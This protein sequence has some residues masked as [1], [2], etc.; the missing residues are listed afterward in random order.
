MKKL[1]AITVAL[2]LMASFAYAQEGA[3][4]ITPLGTYATGLFDEGGAEIVTYDSENQRAIVVNSGEGSSL[5]FID[6]SDPT[7]PTLAFSVDLT[8][9][10]DGANSV[11]YSNGTVAVAVQA[12]AVDANGVVVF[13][14]TEGNELAVVTAGALPDMVTFSPDGN[15]VLVANEGEPNDAYDID[16]EGTVSIIDVSGG[17]DGLTDDA[18][19][20]VQFTDVPENIRTFGPNATPAQDLEPEYIAVSP[21][22]TTAYV[23][24]QENN[25][26]AVID[27]A[28]ASVAAIVDL[29][30]KDYSL[31]ENA[32][33]ASNEDGAINIQTWPVLSMYQPD[34][35]ATYEVEGEVYIVTA[36][37][38]DAR[39]YDGF[40]EEA[41]VADITL[42]E[43]AF[44]NAAELQAEDQLGRL[45]ITTTLGDTD[46]DG[47]FDALY[48][49]GAR[50]FSIWNSAGELVFDSTNDFERITA[51]LI[52]DAFNSQG[53]NESFDNRSDDKGPEPEA[54]AIGEVD[55]AI[56]AFIAMERVGGIFVYDVSDP[57]APVY[58]TYANNNIPEGASEELT[59]G[60]VAPESVEFVPADASPTGTPLL[61]V[62][63]EVSG[64][65]TVWEISSG[66]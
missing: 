23:V 32:I 27:I 38:G 29:G 55:G 2:L 30:F 24:M 62:G 64:T 45:L 21:D 51:E 11:D 66:M 31:E 5:D 9:Y 7:T 49:Y 20:S 41:R 57:V 54:V 33:D 42:D 4:S 65:T 18:V 25:A 36:N 48:G 43:E 40:S 16:P 52:P 15:T 34:T 44:P 46:G 3:I 12:E 39:D 19:T 53:A 28:S 47:D 58:V 56:Y 50:S 26:L 22:S 6:I 37:E 60:D 10:G 61:I 59:A 63:N 8:G 14:D 17:V 35:I 1:F 13:L